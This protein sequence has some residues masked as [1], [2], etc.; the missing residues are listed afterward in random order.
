MQP[1][2][3]HDRQLDRMLCSGRSG[4]NTTLSLGSTIDLVGMRS[5]RRC[6]LPMLVRPERHSHNRFVVRGWSKA[7]ELLREPL[8]FSIVSQI[9]PERIFANDRF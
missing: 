4:G 1:P 6:Q 3:L 7:V 5:G 8:S 9:Y 2:R